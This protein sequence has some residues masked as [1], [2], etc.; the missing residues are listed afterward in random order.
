MADRVMP[1]AVDVSLSPVD[2]RIISAGV[3]MIMITHH[4]MIEQGRTPG[5]ADLVMVMG[6]ESLA[7]KLAKAIQEQTGINPNDVPP[8]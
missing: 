4:Q 8:A 3:E 1:E 7:T 5:D 2:I 6:A